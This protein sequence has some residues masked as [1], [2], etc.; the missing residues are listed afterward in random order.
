MEARPENINDPP[1]HSEPVAMRNQLLCRPVFRPAPVDWKEERSLGKTQEDSWEEGQGLTVERL[2]TQTRGFLLRCE[3]H[4]PRF[5]RDRKGWLL[6]ELCLLLLVWALLPEELSGATG[7]GVS[8][9]PT[10]D[11][12]TPSPAGRP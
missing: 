12:C 6:Q 11:S 3:L 10:L 4:A 8:T 7:K 2:R 9:E 5:T 1:T